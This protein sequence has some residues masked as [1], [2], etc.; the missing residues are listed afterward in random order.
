MIVGFQGDNTPTGGGAGGRGNRDNTPIPRNHLHTY[1][2]TDRHTYM[3]IPTNL[4]RY[5]HTTPNPPHRRGGGE[6]EVPCMI[7]GCQGGSTPNPRNHPHRGG[8][9]QAC[10]I[11]MFIYLFINLLIYFP[12]THTTHTHIYIYIHTYNSTILSQTPHLFTHMTCLLE[13]FGTFFIGELLA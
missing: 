1:I 12:H 5:I 2:H 10:T 7:V 3:P 8:G 13:S 11:Y 9:L 4:R 6:A